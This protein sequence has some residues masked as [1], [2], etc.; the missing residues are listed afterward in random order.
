MHPIVSSTEPSSF[1]WKSAAGSLQ[2]K[3][4]VDAIVRGCAYAAPISDKSWHKMSGK[5][6]KRD[7]GTWMHP[8]FHPGRTPKPEVVCLI[9][10]G[11]FYFH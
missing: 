3:Y 4:P 7:R 2:G 9:V 11:G 10:H 6:E 5:D 1:L 8:P